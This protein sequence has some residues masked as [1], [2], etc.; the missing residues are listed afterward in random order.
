MFLSCGVADLIATS[1]GGR[2]RKCAEEFA[3]R[4][5]SNELSEEDRNQ[6]LSISPSASI[7]EI[8]DIVTAATAKKP[9]NTRPSPT[10][11][12]Q[13]ALSMSSDSAET[14]RM[15][16]KK[17]TNSDD[18][19]RD[20]EQDLLNGQKLQGVSTCE[21]VM[22]FLKLSGYLE[23]YPAHF[24]LFKAIYKIVSEGDAIENLFHWH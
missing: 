20:I 23:T 9:V 3:R 16:D 5:Q 11:I 12:S 19:W 10:L 22:R 2:N 18:I 24:P 14:H 1:F 7:D 6:L 21:E 8:G 15:T 17:L 13:L 4:R